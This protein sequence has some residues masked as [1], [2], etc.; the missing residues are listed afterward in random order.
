MT[1]LELAERLNYTDKAVSKWE[2][3]ESVPDIGVLKNIADLFD[4]TVD[5]LLQPEHDELP[6]PR[7]SPERL[8]RKHIFILA[9]SLLLV[10]FCMTFLFMLVHTTLPF[11]IPYAWLLF[12]YGVPICAVVWL[13]LNA[14]FF[15]GRCDGRRD[16]FLIS[17]LMWS[18]LAAVHLTLVAIGQRGWIWM[19]YLLGVPGQ[20]LVVLFVGMRRKPAPPRRLTEESKNED[21]EEK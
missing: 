19:I 12:V 5:Y 7:L 15:G 13:V 1:Q 18:V 2:R 9:L 3:G 8:R 6:S 4:V 14:V 20:F 16:A 11:F 21:K 10:W 17:L